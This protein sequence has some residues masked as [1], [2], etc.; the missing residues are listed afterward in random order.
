MS[1]QLT[2]KT[3]NVLPY[4][5]SNNSRYER[6]VNKK[7]AEKS[8]S[9]ATRQK[10]IEATN[11]EWKSMSDDEKTAFMNSNSA[12]TKASR[13]LKS[14]FK[15]QPKGSVSNTQ[16]S[17]SS[18]FQSLATGEAPRIACK[19][20]PNAAS[21]VNDVI[22][23]GEKEIP[24]LQNMFIEFGLSQDLTFF[25]DDI[26]NDN[27]LMKILKSL[28]VEWEVFQKLRNEYLRGKNK[29]RKSLLSEKI[30]TIQDLI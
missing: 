18:C 21:V 22:S 16:S 10:F 9:F 8:N 2:F 5:R 11:S 24:F 23:E 28:R 29:E 17:L 3:P 15:V 30:R 19:D 26:K 7:W 27:E 12:E 14:Y 4:F 20:L 25:Q 13:N 6:F 1:R